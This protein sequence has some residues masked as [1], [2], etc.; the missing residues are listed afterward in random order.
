MWILQDK[1][2]KHVGVFINDGGIKGP[3]TLYDNKVL[4]ENPG[5]TK[6]IWE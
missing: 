6:F 3:K 1:R 4:E 5:I 2:R